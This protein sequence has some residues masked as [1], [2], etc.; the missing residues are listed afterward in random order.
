MKPFTPTPVYR[1]CFLL[2]LAMSLAGV[3]LMGALTVTA[4]SAALAAQLRVIPAT[5][6]V[7]VG[8]KISVEVWIEDV[9]NLYG[10]DIQLT[11][12]PERFQVIDANPAQAGVQIT[13]RADLLAPDFLIRRSADNSTGLI[14]YAASQLN[15]RPPVSGTGALFSFALQATNSGTATLDYQQFTLSTPD[16]EPIPAGATGACFEVLSATWRYFYIPVV[17]VE[18]LTVSHLPETLLER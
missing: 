8:G 12:D 4:R 16:G 7:A 11:F 1:P 14:W 3:F 9:A 2:L 5:D 17:R 18:G 13:P 10:V 6:T 15:P